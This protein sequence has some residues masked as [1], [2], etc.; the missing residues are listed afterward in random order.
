MKTKT[1]ENKIFWNIQTTDQF[2]FAKGAY[3]DK[4]LELFY[5]ATCLQNLDLKDSASWLKFSKTLEFVETIPMMQLFCLICKIESE[6]FK[7]IQSS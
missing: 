7:D 6:D 4:M 2:D 1:N 3:F 5:I